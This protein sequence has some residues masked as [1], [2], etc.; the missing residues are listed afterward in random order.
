[1][2]R[3]FDD[4]CAEATA[5]DGR[6]RGSVAVRT[7]TGPHHR[8]PTPVVPVRGA[9]GRRRRL[10]FF[11]NSRHARATGRAGVHLGG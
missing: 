8:D 6:G 2:R 7:A 11:P 10:I 4:A 1:M 3:A 9:T 5:T